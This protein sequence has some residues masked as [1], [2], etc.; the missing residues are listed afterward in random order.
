M[1]SDCE[2]CSKENVKLKREK[3]PNSGYKFICEECEYH[4]DAYWDAKFE[5]SRDD[6]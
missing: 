1:T 2:E 3:I 4:L 5:A 6:R